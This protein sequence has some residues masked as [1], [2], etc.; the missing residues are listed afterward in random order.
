MV[1]FIGN[2]GVNHNADLK[3]IKTLIKLGAEAGFNYLKFNT[4]DTIDFDMFEIHEIFNYAEEL[5]I[6]LFC[7]I[8]NVITADII[9]QYTDICEIPL[10]KNTDKEFINYIRS[11]FKNI[12]FSIDNIELDYLENLYYS[13]GPQMFLFNACEKN[14]NT[15][16]IQKFLLLN[17]V[18]F[19]FKY[20]CENLI[21]HIVSLTNGCEFIERNITL[22]K[23]L[24]GDNHKNSLEPHE[25]NDFINKLQYAN[26]LC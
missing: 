5:N 8:N 18:K 25:Y 15:K 16:S 19:C 1:N 6:T 12:I 2:I 22:C 14:C 10:E 7:S 20:E 13:Y 23:E 24:K 4:C 26:S 9:Y 17:N 11:K 21:P 3:A